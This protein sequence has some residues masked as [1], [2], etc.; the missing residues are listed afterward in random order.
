MSES[1]AVVGGGITGLVAA[2]RLQRAGYDV[3]LF[4]AS[5]RTGGVIQSVREDGFL[6]ECGPNT[7]M[8]TS[9]VIGE[10]IE[11][12][13]I[14]DRR[15]DSDPAANKKYVIRGGRTIPVPES[16][17][18][19]FTS[20]LFSV[21]AKLALL[22]EPFVPRGTDPDESLA[23]FVRRRL[24]QEFL[25]Y[26]INPF[27]A[28]VYA[29]DPERL[30]VREAFPKVWALEES[31][32]S[33]IRGQIQGARDRKR[34]GTASKRNAPKLSFDEGIETLPRALAA[35]LGD[36][37]RLQAPVE[38]IEK[39][40][41]GWEVGPAKDVFGAVV[42]ALPAFA[43]AG[44][45]IAGC[46]T[47]DLSALGEI[48]YPPVA[49]VVLG[50]RR[51]QVDHPLDGFGALVPEVEGKKILGTI[52]STTLFPDRAPDHHVLLTTYIGGTR[53]PELAEQGHERLCEIARLDLHDL[54]GVSGAPLFSHSFSY[55]RAI[56]QYEV[57]YGRFREVMSGAES[58]APGVFF[59]GHC[60]DG[61]ALG[62]SIAS[63]AGA[64][65]RVH[66]Y[67]S[68]AAS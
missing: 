55:P 19:F 51:D 7:I 26:A 52:F 10:V 27:V 58:A 23:S 35:S 49:S 2:H 15:R 45:S 8:E 3:T 37:I 61:I 18:A 11:E 57:G 1:V 68:A 16:P 36:R 47:I 41:G 12:L 38:R 53:A 48:R 25:D 56:P 21:R 24:G 64:A 44:L 32:G 6:A 33:L 43:L 22:R 54:F 20:P 65:E 59:V 9:P 5:H 39:R 4:E 66:D 13:G 67:F 50:F 29:G 60:R 40:Q 14:A 28:G 62:D 31:Y 30:S 34:R 63:G 46:G 42:F 17:P